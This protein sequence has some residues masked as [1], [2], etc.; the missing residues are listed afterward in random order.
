MLCIAPSHRNYQVATW[1]CVCL[2]GRNTPPMQDWK[3][4][5]TTVFTCLSEITMALQFREAWSLMSLK[6][7]SCYMRIQYKR[8]SIFIYLFIYFDFVLSLICISRYNKSKSKKKKHCIDI[9]HFSSLHIVV[10]V[11]RVLSCMC[12][13]TSERWRNKST[14]ECLFYIRARLLFFILQLS[15]FMRVASSSHGCWFSV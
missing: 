10:H 5:A 15:P 7:Q 11:K 14:K 13:F 4:W 6:Q 3:Q 12:V 1:E 8:R 2:T 9:K